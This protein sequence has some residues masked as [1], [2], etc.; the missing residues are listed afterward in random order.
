M[1]AKIGKIDLFKNVWSKFPT[2]VSVIT[3]FDENRSYHGMTAASVTSVS[4]DPLLILVVV[5]SERKSH[6]LIIS[7]Q[8]FGLSFL[9][10]DQKKIADY[11]SLSQNSQKDRDFSFEKKI[12]SKLNDIPVIN[13]SLASMSCELYNDISAGDHTIFIG[14]VKDIIFSDY[15]PLVWSN[16]N[17]GK[18]IKTQ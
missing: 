13:N 16:R 10:N 12:F 11:F 7:S 15:E 1:E 4:L 17:Y 2:G 14:K 5:G 3:T 8:V 9:S 18:F 6:E